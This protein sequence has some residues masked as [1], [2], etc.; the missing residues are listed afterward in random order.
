VQTVVPIHWGTF[1]A[2]TGTPERLEQACSD[3]GI[4]CRVVRL[5]PGDSH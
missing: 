4:N 5:D 2:L 1:P 3:L